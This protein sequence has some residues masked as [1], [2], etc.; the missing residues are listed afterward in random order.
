MMLAALPALLSAAQIADAAAPSNEARQGDFAAIQISY[1]DPDRFAREW[2]V[3]TA[4]AHLST[5][6]NGV[7][8]KPIFV[9]VVFA[10]CTADADG[11][12]DVTADIVITDP[13]G[14]VY[15]EHQ[16]VEVWRAP[17]PA[18]N[19]LALG[20]AQLGLRVEPGE[21]LGGYRVRFTLHDRIAQ[22]DLVTED[23]LTI[24]EAAG[25]P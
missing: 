15:A 7:R 3:K 2:G 20:A 16:A 24:T 6:R 5:T 10:N 14:K 19:L 23:V 4:G 8:N 18:R 1:E 12:C 17:A 22:R 25:A 21:P 11:R 9:T 13:N